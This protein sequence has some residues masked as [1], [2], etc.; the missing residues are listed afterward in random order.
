MPF[1]RLVEV[2]APERS[3]ARHP[4]FQVSL[5]VQNNA[6]A[7]LALPGLRAAGMQAGTGTARFDLE[8]SLGEAR[9]SQGLPAGLRGAVS[10][11]ADLFEV[12]TAEAVSGWFAR[13]LTEVAIDPGVSLRR[14]PVLTGEE[15]SQIVS[16]W[17]GAAPAAPAGVTLAGLFEAQAARTP[18]AVAVTSGS[19][20]VIYGQL[21][22]AADRLARVLAAHGVGPESVVAVVMDRCAGLI[23][24]VLGVLKAGAAYLPVDPGYPAERVAFMLADAAPAVVIASE[25]AAREVAALAGV[26]VLVVDDRGGVEDA[27]A[28]G[29]LVRARPASPAYVIYTSGST[30]R[31]KGVAVTHASVAALFAGTREWFGFGASEVWSWFHSFAF[32][33][34]VWE[35]F[36]A[37]LHGGRVM[38]VPF[39]VSRSPGE[40]AALLARQAVTVLSQTPSA[41]YQLMEAGAGLAVRWVVFGGEALDE[42]RVA[43]QAGGPVLVNMYGIT[44]TTVHVTALALEA[45]AAGPGAGGSPVGRPVAGWQVF[46]LDRW[47]CPVPAGVAGELYVAGAG[48]ARGYAGRAGLTGER[49]VA[50]PFGGAGER[51]YRTGDVARWTPGGELVYCGR[52]DDQVKIRGFRIEPGEIEAVLAAHPEVARAVVTV[53]EDTAGDKRLAAYV[54]AGADAGLAGRLREHAA[55]RLPDYM[56]PSAFVVL[57]ALPLTASGKLDRAALPAPDH[58]AA[59]GG[60]RAPETVAEEIL[61]GLFAAVLGLD[62]VGPEDDFFGLGGHSLLA[63]RLVSRVRSVLDVEVPVRALFAAPTPAGL[64]AWLEQAGPAR[65]PLAPRPRPARVPLSFAQQRLWFIAEMEGPSPAYNNPVAVRLEGDLDPAAL[66]AALGD[67]IGRHEVLRTIFPA[68]GGEPCQQVI[69]VDELGWELP[70]AAVADDREL[71]GAVAAAVSEPFDL[72]ADVPVRA[73]LLAVAADVHVLVVVIH[74]VATDGWSTGV[75]ARDLSVAY[76]ARL[77][78]QPPR[79][80]ALPVQYADYAI[81]QRELLGDEDDPGSLL[82][83]Q[84]AWWRDALAGS[85]PELTLPADR[86]R[87]PVS[88][89]RGHTA[90][91]AVGAEVHAAL[92]ALAREQ[93]VTMF[94][95]VQAALAVLLSKL[96]AGEDIPVGTPVAGRSDEALDDLV[97]FFVNTLVLRTDVSGDPEFTGLLGRVREFWL[98]ALDHQDVPFERLVEVLAPERSL[99]RHPLFQVMLAVQNNAQATVSLPG[100]RVAAMPSGEP[101]A[102]FDVQVSLSEVRDGHGRPGG[103]RGMVTAA[104]GLFDPATTEAIGERLARVLAVV[105]ADPGVRLR[106]VQVMAEG[107]RAQVVSGWNDTA[108]E[109]AAVTVPELFEAVVARAPDAVAVTCGGAR[110]SYGELNRQANR[111]AR[112]L[113]GLGAGPE[114]VVA[115]V[116]DRSAELV[117][118]LLAVLKAGAAYLPVDPGYPVQRIAYM[119]SQADPVAVIA[120]KHSVAALPVLPEVPVLAWGDPGLAARLAGAADADLGDGDRRGPLRPA[121]PAYV[122]FTSGSTGA[123]KGVVVTHASVDRLVRGGGFADVGGGD[124]VALASSVSFDAATFEIWGALA[125]GAQLAVAPGG[126]LSAGE[127]GRFLAELRVSVLWLT[128]GLFGQVAETDTGALAG[129]RVLLAGGDVLPAA[130]CRAVLERAPGVRLVNGY[131]PTENTTFTATW[132]VRA[133]DL[134][135]GFGVPVGRP[136]ADTRVFVLDRWLCPVPTGVTGELYTA[137]AGLARGYLAGAPLTAERFVACP[138]GAPGMLM[139]RTG[140]V[141]RWRADGVLEFC[142]RADEQVKVRGFRVEPGEIETAL[143]ACPGVA[144]AVV[145]VREDTGDRRLVAYIVAASEDDGALAARAREY[146][147]GLLPEY[148]VPAAIVVLDEL[149]LTANGKL[150]RAALPAPDYAAASAGDSPGP[151]TVAEEIICGLF[152][153]ILGLAQVGA[154]DDFFALGGH[155]LLAVRLVS[156]VRVVLGAEL[157]VRALFEAPTPA[158]LAAWL[159]Q[160]GHAGPARL[161][162]AR[163]PR[164]DRVPLSFAQQRLWFTAQLE[165][166]SPVYNSPVAVRLEGELDTGALEAAL[167]DVI[168]RHEV[169]RTIFPAD[170]GEPCQQ[171][172]GVDELGWELPATAVAEDE[173]AGVVAA[174]VRRPFDLTA[175]VPVRAR[176]LAVAADVHVLVVVIHHVATDGWST[177]VLAR[178]LSVAYTARLAGQPPAWAALPVQYADYAMWQGELLGAENEPGSLLSA[179]VAW[180]RDALAELPPE[181]ALPADHPRPPVP[182]HRGHV[183]PL[184][185]AAEVHADLAALAREQGVTVFM[186]VQA[187]L[188]VLLSK[189]GA[190]DDIPVGTPVAGRS[191][192]ALDNLVGTFVNTLVLRTD[193]SGDPEFTG[194]LA[195]VREFWLGALDHQDVPFERLVEALA[196]ERSL[197]RHPL[198]QVML[199]VQ[200][201]AQATVSLPGL[202]VIRMPSGTGALGFDLDIALAEV[203]DEQGRPAGLRGTVTAAA[204]LFDAATGQTVSDRFAR[205]LTALTACPQAPLRQVQLLGEE[206]RAQIVSGW[207][208]T[209]AAESAATLGGGFD[210]EVTVAE[211]FAIRAARMPDAVAV[212]CDQERVSYGE[213]LVRASRVA[214]LL[215]RAGVGA[216]SV[217]GVCVERG[218]LMVAAIVGVWLAGAA[219]VPLDPDYPAERLEFMLADSGAEVLL[220]AGGAGGNLAAG[221]CGVVVRL[222]DAGALGGL[223]GV[224]PPGQVSGAQLAYVIY[225]SGSTGIP[226]GVG[227]AH[228]AVVNLAGAL[229]GALGAGPGVRVLQFASFS[230]DASVLDLVVTLVSGGALVIASAADRAEPGLVAGLVARAGVQAA[231]V[232]PSLLEVADPAGWVPVAHMVAGSEPLSGRL[233][234]VWAPGRRLVHAYGPTEATVI[235][236]TA[237]MGTGGGVPPIGVPVANTRL[238]VLDRWLGRCRP[239][240]PESCISPGRG[241]R[242][243][244]WGALP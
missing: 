226:N 169:L 108:R 31:P 146:A 89:Y 65:L 103:L 125:S 54:V 86:P 14:L 154:G 98:G 87:P 206:E 17:G 136:V 184:A 181:L 150:D 212:V 133:A 115:V 176:L 243:G 161:A 39:A 29:V 178:D 90:P 81:W 92:A 219:Y 56:V 123:P 27:G 216:E 168:G 201:N 195:R 99:A 49:F 230:F 24:A 224:P 126:V 57:D 13:V 203:R 132:P 75:L 220:T 214:W 164:P 166:P 106:R 48:L 221:F 152:A 35:L 116:M 170:G 175:D 142:G 94:M 231:S 122:M 73:R 64:A 151:L 129:L 210:L 51:M 197:A 191:D 158:A 37:L 30:G 21:D 211:L 83:G 148:M 153:E 171:V 149:P 185:V 34:S 244:T 95:V 144:R 179:Q 105:A 239:G 135:G 143:A 38:V 62:S 63:V 127:L 20:W 28:G 120:S 58:A 61:C 147:A 160:A 141:A 15:R 186:V 40:F 109:V 84:L 4:L 45:G 70:A 177:G 134:N 235:A 78:G 157:P 200:N 7:V 130:A 138:F 60:G 118:A 229:R 159:G 162:L 88:G 82:S 189:L 42:G 207:N 55:G 76:A 47:L 223:P 190:G 32:D 163:R 110:L 22:A 119:L 182:S 205:V 46:V 5:T 215:R 8:V 11:A 145:I 3:L 232:A 180:W 69:G 102:R 33:F 52:A 139:Y 97:G 217:A 140:D 234:E 59:A 19:A 218:P 208:D 72:T 167:A 237:V 183:M 10:A 104:A 50:C 41:F 209:A 121:H 241:W 196:P 53:R 225:T 26:A 198:F 124:V 174:V 66:E 238:F 85:P 155:S 91:L 137:G 80:A 1:E 96:G 79:W 188:A 192:E 242:E 74:H 228:G 131:G 165:G 194:L 67:V 222:D 114:T 113:A 199:A 156:R 111:L 112:V 43:G 6:P 213:L 25:A 173:L 240:W 36:G 93:G 2:L 193:V 101:A 68:D 128:A 117:T 71:A 12:A 44:E 23:V 202:R 107:E 100:L 204:D 77:T 172:I 233:A 236:A 187:A 16:E 9:D 227:V 18:D